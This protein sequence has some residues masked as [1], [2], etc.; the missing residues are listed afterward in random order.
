MECGERVVVPAERIQRV[1]EIVV[2]RGVV[3][4]E[5][6]RAAERV[7]RILVALQRR[8]RIAEVVVRERKFG[9]ERQRVAKA[10]DRL[11]E[12]AERLQR[13][14][15]VELQRG[16]ARAQLD[17]AADEVGRFGMLPC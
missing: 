14:A 15:E 2:D 3:G 11:V 16:V 4:R 13:V 12:P 17:G 10:V 1:A 6:Q 8:I 9:R 5:P 7:D